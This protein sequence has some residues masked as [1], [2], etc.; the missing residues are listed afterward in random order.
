[1]KT[2]TDFKLIWKHPRSKL[3]EI[4]Y[5]FLHNY[6]GNKSFWG[7]SPYICIEC[8]NWKGDITSTEIGHLANLVREKS[9][10]SCCGVYITTGSYAPSA[11][12]SI[13]NARLTDRIIIVPI[14][15]KQLP[16]LV[17]KGFKDT[18]QKTCE[19]QVFKDKIGKKRC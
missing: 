14:D 15:G 12:E 4:D 3:G 13:K 9:P 18:V 11:S 7:L 2:Q 10:L 1:M 19:E 5:V 8:K 17:E 6:S 16:S